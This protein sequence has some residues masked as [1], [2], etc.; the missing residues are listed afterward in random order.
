MTTKLKVR[1]TEAPSE[2][3]PIVAGSTQ[4]DRKFDELRDH[5]FSSFWTDDPRATT[6]GGSLPALSDVEETKKSYVVHVG[7][8]GIPK[9]KID[10]RL[11]GTTLTIRAD[12]ASEEETK[13]KNFVRRERSYSGFHRALELPE[14]ILP[15]K[16][17][18]LYRDGLLTVTV[19]KAN[20]VPERKV[21]VA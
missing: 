4:I 2:I 5:F 11:T 9:E 8:P 6:P 1:K 12:H 14:S 18:A 21:A 19:P 17:G 13:T 16:V 3:L 20:P 15:E 7:L 10:V